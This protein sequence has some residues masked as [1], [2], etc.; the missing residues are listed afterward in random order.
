MAVRSAGRC[1][2]EVAGGGRGEEVAGPGSPSHSARCGPGDPSSPPV[3]DE[4]AEDA[5]ASRPTRGAGGI[6]WSRGCE[7]GRAEEDVAGSGRTEEVAGGG[8]VCGAK[9]K[10]AGGGPW[11]PEEEA[12]R[13]KRRKERKI[14]REGKRKKNKIE[15]EGYY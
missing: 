15:K 4:E 14:K 2:E 10:V 11:G 8:T 13:G 6:K 7:R 1:G 5:A 9:K 3:Q 12:T